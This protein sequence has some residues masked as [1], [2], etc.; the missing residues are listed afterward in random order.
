MAIGA[1]GKAPL[2]LLQL[3]ASPVGQV[4]RLAYRAG[5]RLV[6][7]GNSIRESHDLCRF[8]G[9]QIATEREADFDNERIAAVNGRRARRRHVKL[10][11]RKAALET[12]DEQGLSD[13]YDSGCRRRHDFDRPERGIQALEL[14]AVDAFGGRAGF[15]FARSQTCCATAVDMREKS[16]MS[17]CFTVF[18]GESASMACNIPSSTPSG[19]GFISAASGEDRTPPAEIRDARLWARRT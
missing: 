8:V 9:P 10:G 17:T 3:V 18:L 4:N 14:L 7:K 16:S 11:P 13:G 12:F 1:I 2:R 19:C 6:L 15:T 5:L